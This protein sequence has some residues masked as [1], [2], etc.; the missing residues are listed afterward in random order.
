MPS[1][2]NP[3]PAT[4]NQQ[5]ITSD[6]L[7]A[8]SFQQ[9]ASNSVRILSVRVDALTYADLLARIAAFIAEGTPHQIATVNPE[10]VME[11]RRRLI[12]DLQHPAMPAFHD[13]QR[14]R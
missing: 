14:L 12:E 9:P 2:G 1:A 13:G 8:N 4:R 3:Q 6:Q 5:P 7:P 11:A 10:F